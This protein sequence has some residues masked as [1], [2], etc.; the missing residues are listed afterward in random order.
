MLDRHDDRT[1]TALVDEVLTA[2][3]VN[4]EEHKEIVEEARTGYMNKAQAALEKRLGQLREGKLVE[5][6]FRL[7]PPQDHSK[8]FRTVITML[9]LHK[10][11]HEADPANEAIDSVPATIELKAADVQRFILNDWSW[12][13][14]FL[15][16]NSAYSAKATT[17]LAERS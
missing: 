15:T 2:L 1:I 4:L 5:L 16:L 3:R 13:D 17:L 11:A 8:D 9:E 6:S 10:A 7:T 12:M 14:N